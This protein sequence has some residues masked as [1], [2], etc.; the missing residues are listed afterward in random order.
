MADLP[1]GQ[2]SLQMLTAP[3]GAVYLWPS[4]EL[5]YPRRLA[6]A[7][8]RPDLLVVP[9][10]WLT[11]GK[12]RGCYLTGLVVDHAVW[13]LS[14]DEQDNLDAARGRIMEAAHEQA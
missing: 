11:S 5:G 8:G 4:G 14:A 12:W 7:V 2:T 13:G 9:P 10:H 6:E 3:Q 1:S